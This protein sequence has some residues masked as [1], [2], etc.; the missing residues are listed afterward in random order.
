[1]QNTV[2]YALLDLESASLEPNR[3]NLTAEVIDIIQWLKLFGVLLR[4]GGGRQEC[5]LSPLPVRWRILAS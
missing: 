5:I 4:V 1:V 2:A 3:L